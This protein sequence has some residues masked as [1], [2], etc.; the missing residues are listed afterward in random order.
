[1]EELLIGASCDN[2]SLPVEA[3][4]V[5][6][7]ERRVGRKVESV[8]GGNGRDRARLLLALQDGLDPAEIAGGAQDAA[9]VAVIA[10]QHPE[11]IFPGIV[12]D[13][14]DVANGALGEGVGDA[15]GGAGVG[16]GVD[17]DFIPRAD[18]R[19]TLPKI[20]RRREPR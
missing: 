14:V 15:P 2:D 10:G 5:V 11:T 6:G 7:F 16:G 19:S 12:D 3:V 8:F 4:D 9:F 17:V 13:V 1:M 18:C 20:L